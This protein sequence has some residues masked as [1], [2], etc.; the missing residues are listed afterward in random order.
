MASILKISNEE[1]RLAR[2][3]GFRRKKPKKPA[4]KASLNVLQG[5]VTRNNEWV[6]DAKKRASDFKSAQ[7]LKDAIRNA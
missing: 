7:K 6:K 5:W 1:L 2:K 4:G 3:G